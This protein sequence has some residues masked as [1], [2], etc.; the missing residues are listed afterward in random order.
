MTDMIRPLQEGL[1]SAFT[2]VTPALVVTPQDTLA[3]VSSIPAQ[4]GC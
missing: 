2:Q 1:A 4:G 3:P